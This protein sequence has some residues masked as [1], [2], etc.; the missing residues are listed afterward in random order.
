LPNIVSISK[1]D[2]P[3]KVSQEEVKKY[4]KQIFSPHFD[5]MERMMGIFDNT[6]I[7][8]RNFCKP[9]DYYTSNSG[10]KQ[11]NDEYVSCALNYSVKAI[12]QCIAS[13]QIKKEE[14][15]DIIFVSSTGL[16]T[17]SIDALIVNRL[18][19]NTHIN[20]LPV[21]GLGCAGGVSGMAKANALAKANPKAVIILVA[22]ELCSLTFLKTD[23]D[24]SNFV[25]SS[26]FSDGI[27]ACII[28]GDGYKS[29]TKPSV[30]ILAAQS[31]LYY[32]SLDIMGWEFMDSGFKVLFSRD[33][34]SFIGKNVKKDVV[35]FLSEQ[36]LGLNDIKNYIF[37]PGGKKVLEAYTESLGIKNDFLK[38]TREVMNAYGNM[39]SVTF[40]YVLERFLSEGFKNG[41]GL[42]MALGPG[43]S[44]EMV[45]VSM[46]NN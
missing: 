2:F 9:L 6:G 12:E 44:C 3:Y 23:Y 4:V 5:D 24:K 26:L 16:A 42:M 22:V 29:K 41:Y 31:R 39:S 40:L 8:Q 17:P 33:I 37:H 38:H 20:R 14:I 21:F 10:F 18:R 32:D 13:A 35:S 1:I 34:P 43:F 45:L 28:K 15:T 36:E 27:A 46:T 7:K 25:A 11:N 19:L 30:N